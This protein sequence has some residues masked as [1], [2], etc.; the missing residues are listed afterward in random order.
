[1][2]VSYSTWKVAENANPKKDYRS[3]R[4]ATSKYTTLVYWLFWGTWKMTNEWRGFLWTPNLSKDGFS[5]RDSIVI[6]PLSR[7]L[8]N[9]KDW[10]ITAEETRSQHHTQRETLSQTIYSSKRLVIFPK[11][12]LLS[13]KEAYIPF[14]LSL[15]RWYLIL[16]SKPPWGAIH[17]S[18]GISHIYMSFTC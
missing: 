9:R 17:F 2:D 1:M 7:S 16:K 10:P 8:V 5:K 18:L 14:P 11:N 12:Y 13:P 15:L 4:H 6:N 3:S